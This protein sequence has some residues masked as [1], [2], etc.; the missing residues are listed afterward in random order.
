MGISAI[1]HE[2]A[3]GYVAYKLGDPTAKMAGRLSINPIKH[4]DPFGTIIFPLILYWAGFVPLILFKPVPINPIYFKH[5]E[6]DGV[7]VALA[8]P[9]INLLYV[10]L[11][12]I[13]I[14]IGIHT[15][16][17]KN[18][19][20]FI[21]FVKYFGQWFI[22]INLMLASFN[23]IPIPPLDGSWVLQAMLPVRWKFYFIKSRTYLIII[24]IILIATGKLGFIFQYILNLFLKITLWLIIG[25]N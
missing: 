17:I 9:G 5:P 6:K 19:Y 22:L 2:L 8:G 1:S 18:S 13:I 21:L 14:R 24:F 4:I 3:H 20:L 11:M 10:F 7:K 23:L 12:A 16:Y 25:G 15:S